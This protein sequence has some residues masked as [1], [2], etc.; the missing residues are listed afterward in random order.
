MPGTSRRPRI[1]AFAHNCD[2]ARGSEEA[3]GW[4]WARLLAG[5]GDTWVLIR[6]SPEREAAIASAMPTIPERD[7]L[8][9]VEVPL[10]S[11][12]EFRRRFGDIWG[13]SGLEY[14]A[15]QWA[16]LR[17]AR[18]LDRTMH[19]DVAWHLTW[20]NVWI[21]SFASMIG[22]PFI[23]GPVG[24]AVAPPWRLAATL[25]WRGLTYEI[26][27][28]I[29][30]AAAR[31]LNPLARLSWTNARLILVQNQET[32]QWLPRSTRSRTVVFPNPILE[33]PPPRRQPREARP[34]RTALFAGR[35]EPLKGVA[36]AIETMVALPDWDLVI[37]GAGEDLE[38]LR[39][40]ANRLGVAGRVDFRG[41]Q[42][43]AE[44]LRLM[45]DEADA[46]LFPSFHEEGGYAV[47]E[48]L[49]SGCPV[50]TLD[51]GAPPILGATAVRSGTK[52]ETIER[53]AAAM[54]EVAVVAHENLPVR[55]LA[56]CREVIRKHLIEHGFLQPDGPIGRAATAGETPAFA[57]RR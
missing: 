51:R 21:G 2:P 36:L 41:W 1:V 13:L 14:V 11:W 20:A 23:L 57:T 45:R 9:V 52:H 43:R 34:R 47:V 18:R 3:A 38:R 54:R 44:V 29:V 19:F 48:A 8:H 56:T 53:L 46:M 15:W 6:A 5:F 10:P 7:W 32:L 17:R 55:D 31:Y 50:I 25:G 35:L 39:Q 24:G 49:A 42:S 30:H 27:R 33:A 4:V 26:L 16:A 12:A 37:C 28:A 40:L 22:P